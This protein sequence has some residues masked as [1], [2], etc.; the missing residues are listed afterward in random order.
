MYIVLEVQRST[1]KAQ[2]SGACSL[3]LTACASQMCRPQTG[4]DGSP[5]RMKCRSEALTGGAPNALTTSRKPKPQDR[6]VLEALIYREFSD[7]WKYERRQ[8]VRANHTG[9]D[10]LCVYSVYVIV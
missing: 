2:A 1:G 10:Y 9:L 6:M 7:I 4:G 8:K 3:S 5:S